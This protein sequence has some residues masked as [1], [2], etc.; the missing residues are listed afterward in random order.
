MPKAKIDES[1]LPFAT[2]PE[3]NAALKNREISCTE[4]VKFFGKRLEN[5]GPRYNALAFSLMKHAH[6]LGQR[7]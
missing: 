4:L 6:G 3:L 1:E 7:H 5:L 2:I